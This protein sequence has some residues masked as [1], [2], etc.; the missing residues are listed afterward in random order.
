M[1]KNS[2]PNQQKLR[3]LVKVA[4]MRV[5][6]LPLVLVAIL[7]TFGVWNSAFLSLGNM[8]IASREATYLIVVPLAQMLA[9]LT[10]GLDLSVGASIALVST[11]SSTVMVALQAYPGVDVLVGCLVGIGVGTLVGAVNGFCIAFFRVSPFL[12]TLGVNFI[13]LS[14]ALILSGG[15]APVYGLPVNFVEILGAGAV[16]GIP[17]PVMVTLLLIGVMYLILSWTRLGRHIYAIGG[18]NEAARVM[19]IPIGR[20][21]FLTYMI[22]GV[23][24]GIAGVM[25]T[26]RAGS[27]EPTLGLSMPLFSIAAAVMG[28]VSLFGGEG[29]LYGA[30]LGAMTITL[31][32]NG[33]DVVGIDSFVQMVI[34]GAILIMVLALDRY[35]RQFRTSQELKLKLR[36]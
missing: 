32:R 35:R 3:E 16:L 20:Y 9:L 18:S 27:G 8:F 22:A 29:K 21:T 4:F 24:V 15:G 6:A 31:L 10:A 11:V 19:G 7:V 23:L 28:G 14:L 25:L 36:R 5:G 34:L 13:A 12:V 26:A 2:I 1:I 30:I 17:V 33:M